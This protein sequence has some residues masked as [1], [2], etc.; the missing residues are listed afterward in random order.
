MGSSGQNKAQNDSDAEHVAILVAFASGLAS[1]L[2]CRIGLIL[3]R[4]VRYGVIKISYLMSGQGLTKPLL[5][6]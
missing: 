3:A 4:F 2:W 1:G 5:Y 6:R